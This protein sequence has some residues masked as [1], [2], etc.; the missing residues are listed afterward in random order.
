MKKALLALVVLTGL[1]FVPTVSADSQIP[2]HTEKFYVNDFANVLSDETEQH[3]FETSKKLDEETSAQIVVVTVPSLDGRDIESYATELFREW[4]IGDKEK[5]SGL[6]FLVSVEDRRL[7]IEVGYGLEGILPDGKV[8]RIRDEH[9]S[10]SL[11]NDK[12]DEGIVNGYDALFTEVS[13][14]REEI[15][16]KPTNNVE[17]V[18]IISGL[19]ALGIVGALIFVAY[20]HPEFGSHGISRGSSG[21]GYSSSGSS[22]GGYSGG[23]GSS[24]GGGASGSF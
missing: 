19:V 17:A 10:P 5:N 3:I 2:Q 1:L 15:G 8:G 11:K 18:E 7:R 20:K 13:E 14:N 9:I 16:K 12:W 24:G 21:S 22:G 4:K 23:G 6:L